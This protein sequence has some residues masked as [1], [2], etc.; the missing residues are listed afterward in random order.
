MMGGPKAQA[1]LP[2]K[3]GKNARQGKAKTRRQERPTARQGKNVM[4]GTIRSV[5]KAYEA[6]ARQGE[7]AK[8]G[9]RQAD[10]GD[11]R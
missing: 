11:A 8:E 7:T 2:G 9:A 6:W 3:A 10:E 5:T 4:M 1:L